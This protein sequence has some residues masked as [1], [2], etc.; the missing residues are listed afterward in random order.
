MHLDIA[1]IAVLCGEF[2]VTYCIASC[3]VGMLYFI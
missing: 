2:L 3:E 1:Q